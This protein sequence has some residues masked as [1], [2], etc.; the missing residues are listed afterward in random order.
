MYFPDSSAAAAVTVL[1]VEPGAYSP[2]VARL[3]SADAEPG[4]ALGELRMLA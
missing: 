2:S 4:H 3:N 1:K